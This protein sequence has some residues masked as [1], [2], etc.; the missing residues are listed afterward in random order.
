MGTNYHVIGINNDDPNL[1]IFSRDPI[2][3]IPLRW[4]RYSTA[5]SDDTT[6]AAKNIIGVTST[7][8]PR[9]ITLQTDDL[10]N[11]QWYLIKDESGGAATNNITVTT[12]AA[13]TIDGAA[14]L[15]IAADYGW[16]LVYSDGVNW[17][18]DSSLV[19]PAIA[20]SSGT[21][22]TNWSGIWASAQ[23]GNID[24]KIQDGLITLEIPNVVSTQNAAGVITMDTVL[25]ANLR[26]SANE[27][28]LPMLVQ[29]NQSENWGRCAILG[30]TGD[31]TIGFGPSGQNFNG[32]GFGGWSGTFTVSYK[33]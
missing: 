14:S 20:F 13:E 12:Q 21:H 19:S 27:I 15:V 22:T 16:A 8:A 29:D 11:G 4:A 7:A 26:P 2:P 3:D 32:T 1:D 28:I 23:A 25:P 18:V 24:Y 9:T 17:F 10:L 5:T 6:T 33:L 30:S 31:I